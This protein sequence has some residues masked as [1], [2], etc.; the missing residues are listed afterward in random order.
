MLDPF[1]KALLPDQN[2]QVTTGYAPPVGSGEWAE[3]AP[4]LAQ[5]PRWPL[6]T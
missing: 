4:E 6:R 5:G 1:G 2:R 3:K